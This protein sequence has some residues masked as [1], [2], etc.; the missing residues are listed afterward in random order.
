MAALEI[1]L[2]KTLNP[3]NTINITKLNEFKQDILRPLETCK[4]R[5]LRMINVV[6]TEPY[7]KLQPQFIK[8]DDAVNQININ[9]DKANDIFKNYREM[10]I[11][12][13]YTNATE[14]IKIIDEILAAYDEIEEIRRNSIYKYINNKSIG[15]LSQLALNALPKTEEEFKNKLTESFGEDANIDEYMSVYDFEKNKDKMQKEYNPANSSSG[16][17]KTKRKKHIKKN[18]KSKSKK[19]KINKIWGHYGYVLDPKSGYHI[20][21]GTSKSMKAIS[22]LKRDKEWH[23]RVNYVIKQ[24]GEFGKKLQQYLK[25]N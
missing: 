22:N 11:K 13:N 21:L 17:R 14:A 3:D 2:N 1:E 20:R 25:N 12:G 10:I 24:Q 6:K 9:E 15:T 4:N 5:Y 18:N 16:G 19:V 7:E 23:K 8:C